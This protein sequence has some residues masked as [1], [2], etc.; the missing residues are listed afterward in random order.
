[1]QLNSLLKIEN[2]KVPLEARE[3]YQA[4]TELTH[5]L[6]NG[7]TF[8]DFED[9]LK[10]VMA[11]EAIRSTGVGQGFAIPHG[12]CASV[13]QLTMAIGKPAEPID[14]KSIDGQPVSV[15]ILLVSPS[16]K[17]GPHIQALARISR[18]MTNMTFR[19]R[20]WDCTSAEALYQHIIDCENEG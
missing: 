13:K 18:I 12:K 6:D 7:N 16:D 9:I 20:I 14:F 3:K 1:M 5:L 17:T 10:T 11:R 2:I 15:I 19:K 4:I 8:T